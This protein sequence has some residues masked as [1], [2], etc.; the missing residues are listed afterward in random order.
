MS[1][2]LGLRGKFYSSAETVDALGVLVSGRSERVVL[3]TS[4]AEFIRYVSVKKQSHWIG[5]I[6]SSFSASYMLGDLISARRQGIPVVACC[7]VYDEA[8]P[9]GV[10]MDVAGVRMQALENGLSSVK[11]GRDRF[12]EPTVRT[13]DVSGRLQTLRGTDVVATTFPED[14]PAQKIVRHTVVLKTWGV[15]GF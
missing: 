7:Y 14:D 9:E 1:R 12:M 13:G 4:A 15:Q 8:D 6:V 3:C 11:W 2:R 5:C 10:I